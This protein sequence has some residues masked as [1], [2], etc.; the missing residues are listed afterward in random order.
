[1]K[2]SDFEFSRDVANGR[3]YF[4]P[5]CQSEIFIEK[6]SPFVTYCDDCGAEFDIDFD[7]NE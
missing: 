2:I 3:L 7:D 4:C 6:D 1:M 5:C